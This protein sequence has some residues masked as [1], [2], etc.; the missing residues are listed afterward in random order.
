ME[1]LDRAAGIG[2]TNAEAIELTR[3]HCRNARIELVNGNSLVGAAL[4]VPLGLMEVRC[5]HAPPPRAQSPD[6]LELAIKFYDAHCRQCAHRDPTGEVPNLATVAHERAQA[7]D[8]RRVAQQQVEEA[9][10]R[11]YRVRRERRHQGLVGQGHVVEDLGRSMDLID[12]AEPGWREPNE[13]ERRAM[14]RLLDTAR[15]APELFLPVLVDSLLELAED[16]ADSTALLTLEA[17]ARSGKCSPRR[18]LVV[19]RSVLIRQRSCEAGRLLVAL[20]P[21]L[22]PSDLAELVD[23]LID[24]ASGREGPGRWVLPFDTDGL[25]MASRIDAPTVLERIIAHLASD[26]DRTREAGADAARI[27]IR[28]DSSR[29]KALGRPLAESVHG[30]DRGYHGDAHPASSALWALAE[31]WGSDPEGVRRIVE[32]VASHAEQP[33][34]G[35]L[36]RLPDFVLQNPEVLPSATIAAV[37][38]LVQRAMGDWGDEAADHAAVELNNL[39]RKCPETVSPQARALLGTILLLCAP[40]RHSSVLNASSGTAVHALQQQTLRIRRDGRRRGLA[41]TVGLCTVAGSR[42]ILPE[43]HLLFAA[44]TGDEHQDRTVRTTMLDV[45]TAAVSPGTLRDLLPLV[46]TA[47]LDGDQTVRAAGIGLWAACARVSEVLPEE[48]AELAKPLLSDQ[49][50]VV[51]Q[52]MLAVVADLGLPPEN[53][54]N[55]LPIVYGWV[56][57]Y[58]EVDPPRPDVLALAIWTL[59]SLAR[60]VHDDAQV[61]GWYGCALAYVSRCDPSDREKLL[62]A[63]WPDEL[64][65]HPLWTTVALS[66]AASSDLVDYYNQRHEPVLK[67]LMNQPQRLEGIPLPEIEPLSTMHGHRYIWRALEPVELLQAAGRWADASLIAQDVEGRQ[68]PGDEGEPGRRLACVIARAAELS[69]CLAEGPPLPN[70]LIRLT[71]EVTAAVGALESCLPDSDLGEELRRTLDGARAVATAAGLLLAPIIR[72]PDTSARELDEAA[73]R[74]AAAGP[75]HA[76]GSQRDWIAQAWRIAALLLRYDGA[77]RVA[78]PEASAHLQAARR[79][80]E[81]LAAELG[82]EHGIPVPRTLI[83]FLVDVAVVEDP[84]AAQSAWQHLG[85]VPVPVSLVGMD[86][87]RQPANSRE[88][89]GG[90]DEPPRAVCVA[91]REGV[92]VTDVLV[93]R[94]DELYHLGMTVRL[95]TPPEWATRCIVEPVTTLGRDAIALPRYEFVLSDGDSDAFGLILS[96]EEPLQ[97]RIDQPIHGPALDCPVQVRL[98]GDGHDEPIEVAGFQR[99]RLR[100]FD[101]S[102]D[103]LTQ[104]E[105][106][107]ARLLKMFAALDSSSFDSEDVRAFCRFFAACVRAAQRIMFDKAFRRGTR[108]SEG[109]F[110]DELERLLRSDRELEGRLTRRDPVAGGFDDLLH[111]DIIAE[112]KVSRGGSVAVD[113]CV[114]YLGQPTQYAVGRGSQLSILV[115]LD[116]GRK[117]A[118]PGVIENYLDWL[119]PGLHGLADPQYPSLVGVLIINTNLPVPSAW[120]RHRIAG[121]RWSAIDDG[122]PGD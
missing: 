104:H 106:T 42:A 45:A 24:L 76:S 81:V 39:A 109:Q 65:N 47:L 25:I 1:E 34:Q 66:T 51:H 121:E 107:D 67:A 33:A 71:S 94:R 62:M 90:A 74:L 112:L 100:P 79:R 98:L 61:P 11:R 18:A 53:A 102:R 40:D 64:L 41:T 26:N 3:R 31:G 56:Q 15:G 101:P 122:L 29:I 19:A 20:E 55:L 7:V 23:P 69:Q 63:W 35:E 97:C 91:T 114:R 9:R 83:A 72:D 14:R 86:L 5:K 80:A 85:C 108:V 95:L 77:V 4:N 60:Q 59:R 99:L 2:R 37:D 54:E 115:V 13:D 52:Q 120:S 93:V 16:V 113:D 89:S 44:T 32:N 49:Y 10:E 21:H 70:D 38:F 22:R 116:H 88:R 46:Y 73:D 6:A 82:S 119:R 48:L 36:A 58:A 43:V 17:L 28:E 96:G 57:T 75:A 105:Q 87:I 78:R 111:D 92:P 30:P 27:L 12:R 8:R 68:A 110:H 118:P 84:R 50:A 103:V 117:E